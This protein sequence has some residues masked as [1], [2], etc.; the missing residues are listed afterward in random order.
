MRAILALSILLLASALPGAATATVLEQDPFVADMQFQEGFPLIEAFH[1]PADHD[2]PGRRVLRLANGDLVAAAEIRMD[3]HTDTGHA[4]ALVRYAP[5][6]SLGFWPNGDPADMIDGVLMVPGTTPGSF[7]DNHIQHRVLDLKQ[8]NNRILLLYARQHGV[9]VNHQL[10][11]VVYDSNGARI[12]SRTL[13]HQ[14]ML[15]AHAQMHAYTTWQPVQG[16]VSRV[17]VAYPENFGTESS[18]QW[19]LTVHRLQFDAGM[20]SL[21]DDPGFNNGSP[22]R[23]YALDDSC[24]A[25]A[26]A[27]H[28]DDLKLAASHASNAIGSHPTLYLA[29]TLSHAGRQDIAVLAI[30]AGNSAPQSSFGDNTCG[31]GFRVFQFND[32]GQFN[33]RIAGIQASDYAPPL[34]TPRIHVAATVRRD[35]NTAGIGLA[36][37]DGDGAFVPG[38]GGGTGYV[39]FG[40]VAHQGTG[41]PVD[42]PSHLPMA[43]VRS[44]P[45]L[46]VAGHLQSSALPPATGTFNN[47]FLAIVDAG[48]GTVRELRTFPVLAPDHSGRIG[49]GTYLDVVAD[50]D[51]LLLAGEVADGRLPVPWLRTTVS[52][53]VA[54]RIF[55]DGHE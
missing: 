27:R 47:P 11:L 36:L 29:N 30:D 33:H 45:R 49:D 16:D 41:C 44:G 34:T 52:R 12:G 14:S 53:L 48:L 54:D 40:G 20:T 51:G 46:A 42:T 1:P 24:P 31:S 6:G 5:N 35:C 2:R 19:V 23:S 28:G 7:P 25:F 38:F 32:G 43:L 21:S 10:I 15:P 55:G 3:G 8:I 9:P 37:V 39:F 13:F 4:I 18:P 22:V 17:V 26:Q 50:D